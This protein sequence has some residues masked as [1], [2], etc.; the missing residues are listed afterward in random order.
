M[1][2][3]S[4]DKIMGDLLRRHSSSTA[5]L[6]VNGEL[7]PLLQAMADRACKKRAGRSHRLNICAEVVTGR[8]LISTVLQVVAMAVPATVHPAAGATTARAQSRSTDHGW[9]MTRQTHSNYG[10]PPTGPRPGG[11]SYNDGGGGY[12]GPCV[13]QAVLK[14]RCQFGL[15]RRLR[16]TSAGPIFLPY[17]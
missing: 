17:E 6:P 9:A 2:A 14:M 12:G 8:R 5:P 4:A 7:L 13:A 10:P 1:L 15:Q 3:S 11:D 16:P